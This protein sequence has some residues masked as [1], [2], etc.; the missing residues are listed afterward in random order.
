MG[1]LEHGGVT[2]ESHLFADAWATYLHL[3]HLLL[4]A[5][6][7]APEPVS[8]MQA[9]ARKQDVLVLRRLGLLVH[10]LE[11]LFNVACL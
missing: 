4:G 2:K 3:C 6:S 8:V 1:I 11:Q 10:L 5:N 7:P 9:A